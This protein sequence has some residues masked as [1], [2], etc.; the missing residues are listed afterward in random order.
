[1]ERGDYRDGEERKIPVLPKGIKETIGHFWLIEKD[2]TFSSDFDPAFGPVTLY[3]EN[4][5]RKTY[6]IAISS[7]FIFESKGNY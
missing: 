3:V 6:R 2:T 7:I 4:S 1:M 5:L